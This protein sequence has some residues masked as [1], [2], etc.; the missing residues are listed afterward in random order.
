MNTTTTA[1]ACR[2][3]TVSEEVSALLALAKAVS[4]S[5]FHFHHGSKAQTGLMPKTYATVRIKCQ[6]DVNKRSFCR[7]W[8]H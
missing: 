3:I 4:I 8:F 5:P 7:N 2:L 1:K 6:R